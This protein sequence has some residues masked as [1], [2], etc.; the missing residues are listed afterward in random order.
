MVVA[1]KHG[2]WN[3]AAGGWQLSVSSGESIT[4]RDATA[5]DASEIASIYNHYVEVGGATFDDQP[6]TLPQAE[7][8]LTGDDAGYWMVAGPVV[9]KDDANG[10]DDILGWSS[11][12]RFSARYGYRYSL[13]T[14]VYVSHRQHGRKV[15]LRLMEALIAKCEQSQIHFL[16]ARI[17]AGNQASLDF[18]HRLGFETIGV[19][20]EV[21]KMDG[22]WLDVVLLQ[23][24]L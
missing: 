10:A 9:G 3:I 11:A 15:G 19:Q 16:M 12:R 5:A 1:E 23:K 4:V 17:I 8:L 21:G 7:R 24:L 20:K 22:N 18:H 6:W 13:E 2:C 14:A